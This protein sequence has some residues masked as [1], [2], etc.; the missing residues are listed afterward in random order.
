MYPNCYNL[1]QC[2]HE[3]TQVAKYIY[4]YY[5][6]EPAV[7]WTESVNVDISTVETEDAFP[8]VKVYF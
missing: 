3:M 2:V 6:K 8:E 1:P 7:L 4:I 5:I